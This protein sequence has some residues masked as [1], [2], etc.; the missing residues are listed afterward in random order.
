MTTETDTK[1]KTLTEKI[2]DA[3]FGKTGAHDITVGVNGIETAL[4]ADLPLV[5]DGLAS[6]IGRLKGEARKVA[7][8]GGRL[9]KELSLDAEG[10]EHT[11]KVELHDAVASAKA[12]EAKAET[13]AAPAQMSSTTTSAAAPAAGKPPTV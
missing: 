10:V 2:M 6:F 9:H 1:P 5:G 4:R 12:E 3:V 13:A 11:V 8:E 7:V